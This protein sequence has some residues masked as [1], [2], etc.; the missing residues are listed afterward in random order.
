MTKKVSFRYKRAK[1]LDLSFEN[2]KS[3]N[4]IDEYR[5]FITGF[6][7]SYRMLSLPTKS[8]GRY[9]TAS[10][11]LN[12]NQL[13]GGLEGIRMFVEK[14]FYQ[15]DAL[16]WLDLSHNKLTD[17]SEELL[18]FPNLRTLYMHC[19]KLA[20]LCA[21]QTLNQLPGLRSLTMQENPVSTVHGY[22]I[23]MI[24]LIP[25]LVSLDFVVV[26]S[27]ERHQLPPISVQRGIK[28]SVTRPTISENTDKIV[29]GNP[30]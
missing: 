17:I 10:M 30:E 5:G 28:K 1:P 11:L 27:I 20:S 24:Y 8:R 9:K 2:L 7:S 6:V 21:V 26:T 12:N 18:T 19:N 22:R 14:L 29:Q 23:S 3:L 25:L 16:C 15:P 13:T 4:N